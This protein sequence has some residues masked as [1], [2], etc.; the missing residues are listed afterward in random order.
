MLPFYEFF[1]RVHG[2]K[3]DWLKRWE[4]TGVID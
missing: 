2:V 3:K 4:E 1:A